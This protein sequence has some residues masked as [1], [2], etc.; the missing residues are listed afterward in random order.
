MS[1][2]AKRIV[3]FIPE[4]GVEVAMSED[5]D[6]RIIDDK[7]GVGPIFIVTKKETDVIHNEYGPAVLLKDGSYAYFIENSRHRIDG[8]SFHRVETGFQMYHY[9]GEEAGKTEE[10]FKKYLNNLLIG[11][12]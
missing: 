4:L 11:D 5:N 10:E 7:E 1:E 12:K 6:C 9:Q 8:P 2:I 3:K